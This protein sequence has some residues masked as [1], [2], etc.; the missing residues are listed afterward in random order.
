MNKLRIKPC[1]HYTQFT[2]G[3]MYRMDD[4][5]FG[6][7]VI[8]QGVYDRKYNLVEPGYFF[9]LVQDGDSFMLAKL[10]LKNKWFDMG[11]FEDKM[12]EIKKR[13]DKKNK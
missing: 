1:T 7:F 5:P 13:I 12:L 2:P 6:Q 4:M 9:A 8:Y 10:P 3:N 11:S